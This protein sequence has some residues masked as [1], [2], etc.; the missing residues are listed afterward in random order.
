[1]G[2]LRLMAWHSVCTLN[3]GSVRKVCR[4]DENKSAGRSGGFG[5][6]DPL[7]L[8]SAWCRC[9]ISSPENR[10]IAWFSGG[11]AEANSTKS[12]GDIARRLRLPSMGFVCATCGL[13]AEF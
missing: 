12:D 2:L 4:T 7:V 8:L 11:K 5:S 13:E 9:Y 3:T 6:A 10:I 1:M